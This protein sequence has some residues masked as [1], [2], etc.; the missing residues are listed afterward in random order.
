[1]PRENRYRVNTLNELQEE[2]R[3]NEEFRNRH[4]ADWIPGNITRNTQA[5]GHCDRLRNLVNEICQ[6]IPNQYPVQTNSVQSSKKENLT[7]KYLNPYYYIPDEFNFNNITNDE[8]LYLGIE[9]E[10]DN[11][12]KSE[13]NAK[14]IQ[15]FLGEK[16]CYIV[17]DGSLL[18][19][20]E[21]VTHPCTL[22][23]HKKL[24]YKDLFEEL[25]EKGYKSHDTSTCGYHIHINRD[26]FS[27]DLTIQDLCITKILYLIEKYWKYVTVIA[28]RRSNQYSKRF[29]IKDN[30]SMFELL[31]KAKGS[32]VSK[33]NV[34]NLQH[35]KTIE[36]RMFRG[37]LKYE[38]F[39]A[40]MEFVHNL[41]YICKDT[42][43][44][45]IQNIEFQDILNVYQ[46]EY[47]LLY[48]N[49]RIKNMNNTVDLEDEYKENLRRR[50]FIRDEWSL[51]H[52]SL[53]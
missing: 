33:Y 28:R 15:E 48:F 1:M 8:S 19:G 34:V 45:D 36:F 17:G 20:L 42:S 35:S 18:D 26:F 6:H 53:M 10:V 46:T 12:G 24:E 37:T 40:T 14:F 3:R 11:G 49:N 50:I 27:S 32:Y 21:I 38:T 16:N 9:L 2:R 22:Q 13:E 7:R 25:K 30:E 44:E 52:E 47:L 29:G 39:I 31:I 41:A 4:L 5:T 51:F 23:Y 43:L